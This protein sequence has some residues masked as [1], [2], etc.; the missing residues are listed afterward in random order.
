MKPRRTR[1]TFAQQL[2]KSSN[3]N[4]LNK[5]EQKQ[6]LDQQKRLKHFQLALS[7]VGVT[8]NLM[9]CELI[10]ALAA[11]IDEKGETFS[12]G[13]AMQLAEA[14]QRKYHPQPIPTPR[15]GAQEILSS[16]PLDK[17]PPEIAEMVKSGQVGIGENKPKHHPE[18]EPEP[19][20]TPPAQ[21]SA[22]DLDEK[23]KEMIKEREKGREGEEEKLPNHFER[24]QESDPEKD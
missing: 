13:D 4:T 20:R 17:M 22:P 10:H 12:I 19:I 5:M 3:Q 23:E 8:A 18:P 21:E 14:V 9:T 1:E 7:M 11:N 24:N 15:P 2:R 6:L 16:I